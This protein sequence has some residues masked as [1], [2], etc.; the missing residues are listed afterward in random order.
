MSIKFFEMLLVRVT[1][2]LGAT[3]EDAVAELARKIERVCNTD[4]IGD[5]E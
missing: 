1:M 3:T 5:C 4:D 2:G